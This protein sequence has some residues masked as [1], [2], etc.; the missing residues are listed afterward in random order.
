M[1]D[2]TDPSIFK[3]ILSEKTYTA[4]YEKRD[5]TVLWKNWDGATIKTETV[6]IYLNANPPTTPTKEDA[7]FI[8]WLPSDY[9]SIT[10]NTD[11]VAQF[12]DIPIITFTVTWTD[13]DDR[14]LKTETVRSGSAATPP[15]SPSKEGYLFSGWDSEYSN[16]TKDMTIKA[17]YNPNG[18]MPYYVR[19]AGYNDEPYNRYLTNE[20]TIYIESH[21]FKTTGWRKGCSETMKGNATKIHL[22]YNGS[23]IPYSQYKITLSNTTTFTL[24]NGVITKM[25]NKGVQSTERDDTTVTITYNDMTIKFNVVSLPAKLKFSLDWTTPGLEVPLY[26]YNNDKK[27][28]LEQ[29][30]FKNIF[31]SFSYVKPGTTT[32]TFLSTSI[33]TTESE[34]ID[35]PLRY[36]VV[37]VPNLDLESF[38][39]YIYLQQDL[40]NFGDTK[41]AEY[42]SASLRYYKGSVGNLVLSN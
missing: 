13:D 10:A 19:V 39:G 5:F 40:V 24:S 34:L 27:I 18:L 3:N 23:E 37:I 32:S 6:G 22:E 33:K 9:S 4:E 21:P 2:M 30:D 26:V 12:K 16:I 17:T 8:G 1:P 28:N 29:E 14:V 15:S 36:A 42:N 41:K 35:G 20:E 38:Y 25:L 31:M 7:T 11:I